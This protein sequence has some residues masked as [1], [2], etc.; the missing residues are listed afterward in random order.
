MTSRK[1]RKKQQSEP[2]RVAARS[3]ASPVWIIRFEPSVAEDD[4][5]IVGHAA[6]DLA[7]GA[8]DK[9]LKV[10]PKGYGVGLHHPLHGIYKLRASHVR[11]A[12]HVQDTPPEVWI[13]MIGDRKNIW[14][15]EQREILERYEA[16]LGRHIIRQRERDKLNERK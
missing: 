9:K 15:S 8:I 3:N 1:A 7:K 4:L 14:E 13:L 11:I 6:F 16:E 10:D 2:V 12:Y 5:G